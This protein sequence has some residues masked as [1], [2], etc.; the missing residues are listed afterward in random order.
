MNGSSYSDARADLIEKGYTPLPLIPRHPKYQ[1]AVKKWAREGWE[2]PA[3]YMFRGY[4]AGIVCGR[5]RNSCASCVVGVDLSIITD[6]I[7]R[8][9]FTYTLDQL[10][11]TIYRTGWGRK[12]LLLYRT[13]E[14][15]PTTQS[16]S[17]GAH[18]KGVQRVKL[19]GEGSY[20][21]VFASYP[22]HWGRFRWPG[23]LG[24]PLTTKLDDLPGVNGKQL[25]ELINHFEQ[26][27]DSAG[28]APAE[29]GTE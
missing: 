24:S 5:K 26:L 11:E 13:P 10:G 6:R 22:P 29:G 20:T 14:P 15:H 7:A 4:G 17:Y 21:A 8:E 27:A 23:V 12:R 28:L 16:K 19:F 2:P 3:G 1:P 18:V 25:T 9:M